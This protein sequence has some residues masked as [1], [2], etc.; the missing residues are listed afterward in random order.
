MSWKSFRTRLPDA[1][2]QCL[3]T[4][5]ELKTISDVLMAARFK[6][7]PAKARDDIGCYAIHRGKKNFGSCC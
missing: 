1:S 4:K 2:Q 3:Y 7:M 6:E 5:A